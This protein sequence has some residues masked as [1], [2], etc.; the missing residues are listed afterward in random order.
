MAIQ[1]TRAA[2]CKLNLAAVSTMW[3]RNTHTELL[4]AV[5]ACVQN[6]LLKYIYNT[7]IQYMQYT[8]V[9]HRALPAAALFHFAQQRWIV[10][11]AYC[12]VQVLSITL[13]QP[14]WHCLP[15]NHF[16]I[17]VLYKLFKLSIYSAASHIAA[18]LI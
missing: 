4:N 12:R 10:L 17:A 16:I 11:Y 8:V 13:P 1:V 2:L 7:C 3:T 5:A 9:T 14:V 15:H 6:T 18:A